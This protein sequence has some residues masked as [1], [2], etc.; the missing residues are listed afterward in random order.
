MSRNLVVIAALLLSALPILKAQE[1]EAGPI[2]NFG[3]TVV[4]PAGLRGEIY[5]LELGTSSLPDF[6]KLEPVGA[7]YTS[8]LNIPP[9]TFRQGFPGVT[10]RYEWFGI[11]YTGRFWIEKP[12]KYGFGLISDDGA[13]LWIDDAQV[14]DNDGLHMPKARTGTV[15]LA[16]GIHRIRVSYFQGPCT[17]DPCLALILAV[18]RPG[19]A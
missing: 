8:A 13:R 15:K 10:K 5:F 1:I 6:D 4:V 17:S 19:A 16:G 12:G 9:R 3:T 7:I 2:T 11:N 14:I 18:E